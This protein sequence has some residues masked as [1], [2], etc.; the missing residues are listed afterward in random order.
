VRQVEHALI[1]HE[2]GTVEELFNIVYGGALPPGVDEAARR[3]LAAL[4][5]YVRGRD[6]G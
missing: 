3:S 6:Q 5:E 4:M 2:D 1:G